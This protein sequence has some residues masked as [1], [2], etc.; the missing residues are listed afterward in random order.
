MSE[1]FGHEG[2]TEASNFAVGFALGVKIG[3]TFASSHA[4]ASQRILEGLFKPEELEDGKVDR[5]V[6]TESTLVG[7]ECRVILV[8]NGY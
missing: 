4:Q 1:E 6:E 5:R 3:A 2:N 8:E 7:A